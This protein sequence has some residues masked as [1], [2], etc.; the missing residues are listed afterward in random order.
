MKITLKTSRPLAKYL[1]SG[2]TGNRAEL[3]LDDGATALDVVAR[4]GMPPETNYLITLNGAI[5]PM[6]QRETTTLSDDDELSILPP[7][8]GG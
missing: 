3:K 7:L 2:A 6:S 4:L 5:V 1:P 8:K